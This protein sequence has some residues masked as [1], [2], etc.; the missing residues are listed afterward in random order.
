MNDDGTEPGQYSLMYDWKTNSKGFTIGE[1]RETKIEQ[2]VGPGEYNVDRSTEV[3]KQKSPAVTMGSSP[4]RPDFVGQ[5]QTY[6]NY[7][8]ETQK[9]LADNRNSFAQA[10]A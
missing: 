1:K 6:R 8:M 2:T 5:T 10:Q 3:T 9:M 4:S 7:A